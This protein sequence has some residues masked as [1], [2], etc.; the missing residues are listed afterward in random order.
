MRLKKPRELASRPARSGNPAGDEGTKTAETGQPAT[1]CVS[2]LYVR[3]EILSNVSDAERTFVD[4]RAVRNSVQADTF[5]VGLL[6]FEM[7]RL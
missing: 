6:T 7:I 3:I 2:V 1:Q 4:W 5:V